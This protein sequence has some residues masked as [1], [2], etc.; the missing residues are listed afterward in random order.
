[1]IKGPCVFK[2]WI[3]TK[4]HHQTVMFGGNSHCRSWVVS[5]HHFRLPRNLTWL[6]DLRVMWLCNL[7]IISLN[8]KASDFV[9]NSSASKVTYSQYKF[10]GHEPP[11]S[12][13]VLMAHYL[14]PP[15]CKFC[16]VE[17]SWKWRHNVLIWHV[18]SSDHVI[19][20]LL[21]FMVNDTLS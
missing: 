10:G 13:F 14:E 21:D 16:W 20:E 19:K 3:C 6:N 17:A 15:T 1:M 2:W 8:Q 7:R 12:G 18:T 5:L 11:K 9:G 4:S